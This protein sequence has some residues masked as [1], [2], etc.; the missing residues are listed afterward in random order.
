MTQAESAS[1]TVV[2]CLVICLEILSHVAEILPLGTGFLMFTGRWMCFWPQE[3]SGT[4]EVQPASREK[5]SL[6]PAWKEAGNRYG[7][8]ELSSF[9][10]YTHKLPA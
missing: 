7:L 1:E 6:V 5:S 9:L 4:A 2:D 8:G 3:G 10:L